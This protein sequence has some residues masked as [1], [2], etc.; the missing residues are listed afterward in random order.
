MHLNFCKDVLEDWTCQSCCTSCNVQQVWIL[1]LLRFGLHLLSVKRPLNNVW[2][3]LHF[4]F[5]FIV[6]RTI[7]LKPLSHKFFFQQEISFIRLFLGLG[8]QNRKRV[9]GKKPGW[10][11]MWITKLISLLGITKGDKTHCFINE[12]IM[13]LVLTIPTSQ[14]Q[15][16]IQLFCYRPS[17][18]W[19]SLWIPKGHLCCTAL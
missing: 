17:T 13:G 19:Q 5:V 18:L 10:M 15:S 2:S 7:E 14:A 1:W 12:A 11:W 6:S 9:Q 8:S 4:N 3:L 16:T